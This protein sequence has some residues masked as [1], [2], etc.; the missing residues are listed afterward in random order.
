MLKR[1]RPGWHL[2]V[3]VGELVVGTLMVVVNYAAEFT[4][5]LL[6]GGHQEIY[7]FAGLGVAAGALWWFGWFDRPQPRDRE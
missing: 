1:L 3:G 7:F 4:P 5:G 6:P 2:W